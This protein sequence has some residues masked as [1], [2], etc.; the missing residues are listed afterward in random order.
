MQYQIGVH[1]EEKFNSEIAIFFSYIKF[2]L[3]IEF[4]EIDIEIMKKNWITETEIVNWDSCFGCCFSDVI[5][6]GCHLFS[7]SRAHHL[8]SLSQVNSL[9]C[10]HSFCFFHF[11]HKLELVA[12]ARVEVLLIVVGQFLFWMLLLCCGYARLS[13]V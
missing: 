3:E 10:M 6:Q 4:F 1:Y 7:H 12:I 11:S 5:T 8:I 2:G 9:I 13:L